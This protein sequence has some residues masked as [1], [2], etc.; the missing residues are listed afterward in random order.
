MTVENP[1]R[2]VEA[3]LFSGGSPTTSD[4]LVRLT[5][6]DDSTVTE[7]VAQLNQMY[8][9]QG[10][11]YEIRRTGAQ[12][13]LALR[14]QFAP[15]VRR[16]SGRTREVRLSV[17]AI[18][19]LALVAYRQPITLQAIEAARGVDSSAVLRQLRRRDLVDVAESADPSAR[20]EHFRTTRR[21]LQL[22]QLTS[23]EDLPRVQEL[24]KA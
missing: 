8:F 5:G 15:L 7:S 21:F 11:P 22:F 24:D 10:R 4:D 3:L 16:L 9:T 2:L 14:P 6:L 1:T 18:E 23:L 17:A 13:Q 12:Y 20:S 19:V